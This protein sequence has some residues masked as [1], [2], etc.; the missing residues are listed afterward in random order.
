[1]K[2]SSVKHR[3]VSWLTIYI[4]TLR[5]PSLSRAIESLKSKG[6]GYVCTYGVFVKAREIPV[7]SLRAWPGYHI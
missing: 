4:Y 7:N 3:Y 2:H 1:M 6:V 5:G